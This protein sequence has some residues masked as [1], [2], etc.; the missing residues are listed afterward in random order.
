MEKS[1][2]WCTQIECPNTYFNTMDSNVCIPSGNFST[3]FSLSS[4][5]LTSL[6]F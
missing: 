2:K 4:V 3:S 6:S 5:S 1:E